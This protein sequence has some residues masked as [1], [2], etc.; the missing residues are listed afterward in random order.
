AVDELA[1][2]ILGR[3]LQ[4][5]EWNEVHATLTR[6]RQFYESQPDQAALLVEVGESKVD[7]T[8]PRPQLAALTLVANQLLNLDE[9]LNK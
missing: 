9:A 8:T 5:E 6:M 7:A 1:S 2:R 4:P 3:P